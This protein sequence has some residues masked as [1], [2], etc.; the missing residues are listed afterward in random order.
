MAMD[1]EVEEKVVERALELVERKKENSKRYYEIE[2]E[3]NNLAQEKLSIERQDKRG[4]VEMK[5][6]VAGNVRPMAKFNVQWR[7]ETVAITVRQGGEDKK[8]H[9]SEPT[10]EGHEYRCEEYYLH[11]G[12]VVRTVSWGGSDCDGPIDHFLVQECHVGNL[13]KVQF[14]VYKYPEWE[15]KSETQRDHYAEQ[16]GY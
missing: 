7:G 5:E 15:T 9:H 2:R 14:G 8:L 16:M 4:D 11:N 1:K 3:I 13:K 6:L 10:E 12:V